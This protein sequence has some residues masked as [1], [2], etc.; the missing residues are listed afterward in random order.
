MSKHHG[1]RVRFTTSSDV[2]FAFMGATA[3]KPEQRAP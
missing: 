1:M 3:E 2:D